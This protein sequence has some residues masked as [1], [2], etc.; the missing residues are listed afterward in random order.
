MASDFNNWFLTRAYDSSLIIATLVQGREVG[1]KVL[2]IIG[3]KECEHSCVSAVTAGILSL[4]SL[5]YH[6]SLE[7]CSVNNLSI[8]D[9]CIHA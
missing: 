4:V 5:L 6:Q 9:A 8:N 1:N 3:R 2:W 7:E